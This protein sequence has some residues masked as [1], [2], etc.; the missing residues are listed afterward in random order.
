M[1][2]FDRMMYDVD[3]MMYG[4]CGSDVRSAKTVL[5]SNRLRLTPP[6]TMTIL[7]RPLSRFG[8][9]TVFV[10][11]GGLKYGVFVNHQ[12]RATSIAKAASL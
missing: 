4:I 11:D 1:Y 12:S 7:L 2:G 6:T 3:R 10:K 9:E 5:G 8:G